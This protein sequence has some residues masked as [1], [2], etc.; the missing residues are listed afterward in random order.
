MKS[1]SNLR[2]VAVMVS[3]VT[4]AILTI[5]LAYHPVLAS[6]SS[7]LAIVVSSDVSKDQMSMKEL[8]SFLKGEKQ[9]W[10][11]GTRVRLAI[12]DPKTDI[13][14]ET[15]DKLYGMSEKQLKKYWLGKSF[16]GE[17]VAPEFF[18][19]EDALLSYVTAGEGVLGVVSLKT[20]ESEGKIVTI[21]DDSD[22]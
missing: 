16:R 11:D 14:S 7:D 18:K 4:A 22:Q 21:D 6:D 15:A 5:C 12:M 10:S 3:C 19:S 8:R 2:N 1:I 13:G 9:E 20:A 17:A